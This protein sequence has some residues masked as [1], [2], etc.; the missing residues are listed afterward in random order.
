MANQQVELLIVILFVT[1]NTDKEPG[2]NA[3]DK[4]EIYMYII[5][6]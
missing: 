6:F 4:K 1:T 5:S 3:T 2:K